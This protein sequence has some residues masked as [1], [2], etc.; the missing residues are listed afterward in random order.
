[1]KELL[2]T[3]VIWWYSQWEWCFGPH[4]GRHRCART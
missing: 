3:H 4:T 2:Q 1:M